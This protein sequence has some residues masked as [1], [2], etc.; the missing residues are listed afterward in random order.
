MSASKGSSYILILTA[1][2]VETSAVCSHLSLLSTIVIDYQKYQLATL[3]D[4]TVVVAETGKGNVKASIVATKA[5][6]Q[7]LPRLI[8]FVGIA[9]GVKDVSRGDVVYPSCVSYAVSGKEMKDGTFSSSPMDHRPRKA[10]LDLADTTS[11]R[12]WRG[13]ILNG[14]ESIAERKTVKGRITSSEA[15][16]AGDCGPLSELIRQHYIDTIAVDMESYGVM[17]AAYDGGNYDAFVVRGI[18]DR[19]IDKL[20]EHD[21]SWQPKAAATAAG[22]AFEFLDNFLEQRNRHVADE[23]KD[24]NANN[25]NAGT[26][27]SKGDDTA[28]KE[29][30]SVEGTTKHTVEAVQNSPEKSPEKAPDWDHSAALLKRFNEMPGITRGKCTDLK[31]RF[32]G[33]ATAVPVHECEALSLDMGYTIRRPIQIIEP[34][35]STN[36]YAWL[37]YLYADYNFAEWLFDAKSEQEYQIQVRFEFGSGQKEVRIP[38]EELQRMRMVFQEPKQTFTKIHHQG[39]IMTKEI[40][41]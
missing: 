31:I 36:S 24:L 1:L 22:F 32:T 26:S 27:E 2:P 16:I 41:T 3:G 37:K 21:R 10:L 39:V 9:G 8:I 34:K 33:S 40:V 15:V 35:K 18:S 28:Q 13:R 7:F 38:L 17:Q 20:E 5:I 11:E 14:G 12:G 30:L 4:T 6:S 19:R 23:D 29:K 25:S